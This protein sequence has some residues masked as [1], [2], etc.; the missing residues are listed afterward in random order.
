MMSSE[1]KCAATSLTTETIALGSLT[2]SAQAL[3]LPPDAVMASATARVPS[4]VRSVTA[5]LAPSSAKACAVARPMPL[6]APVTR[7][8]LLRALQYPRAA[9]AVGHHYPAG[10]GDRRLLRL[11]GSQGRRHPAAAAGDGDGG[12]D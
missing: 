4:A 1:P 12:D 2:S 5:T 10:P 3:A 9:G 6:A 11:C 8:G 7:T